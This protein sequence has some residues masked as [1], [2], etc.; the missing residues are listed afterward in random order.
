MALPVVT[1]LRVST[2]PPGPFWLGHYR[3]PLSPHTSIPSSHGP[4]F[5]FAARLT[6]R[7]QWRPLQNE[8]RQALGCLRQRLQ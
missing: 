2:S 6:D 1:Y 3:C 4:F 7:T 8:L 5:K